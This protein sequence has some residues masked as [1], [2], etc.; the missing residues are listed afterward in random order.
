[1]VELAKRTSANLL[2][3]ENEHY[4]FLANSFLAEGVRDQME[5][6]KAH[7]PTKEHFC[8][9]V[10]QIIARFKLDL[11]FDGMLNSNIIYYQDHEWAKAARENRIPFLTLCKE[12]P[13]TKTN[14]KVW[15]SDWTDFPY[16]GHGIAVYSDWTKE[17]LRDKCNVGEEVPYRVVGCP[18]TDAIYDVFTKNSYELAQNK[19]VVFFDF[20]EY[21]KKRLWESSIKEF[22]SIAG[23]HNV[24]GSVYKFVIKTKYREDADYIMSYFGLDAKRRNLHITHKLEVEEIASNAILIC[25]FRT[26][27]LIKLMYSDVNVIIINWGEAKEEP[28]DNFITDEF[29]EACHM[30]HSLDEFTLMLNES[31]GSKSSISEKS[32][33]QRDELIQRH[34]YKID[35][36]CSE[37]AFEFIKKQVLEGVENK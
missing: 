10:S 23:K 8:R 16:Y 14:E 29:R 13:A 35:G 24:S 25:G 12:V 3:F 31:L 37:R 11:G 22:V 32:R 2:I 18:R 1:L 20:V 7:D 5:Y 4:T 6:F 19:Y 26:T 15:I 17:I 9:F 33:A 28:E 21:G 36:H 34:L 27:A 30:A